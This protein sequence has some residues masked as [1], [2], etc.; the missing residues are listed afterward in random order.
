MKL[1]IFDIDGTLTATSKVDA[2]C[3]VAALRE[4]HNLEVDN[5]NWGQ[6]K[7]YTDSGIFAEVFE[8]KNSRQ[9]NADEDKQ[10]QEHFIMLLRQEQE[11]APELF[12]EVPGA[13]KMLAD[14][15]ARPGWRI[16]LATG[17][18][19]ASAE[20]KL[21]HIGVAATE[22]P[23]ATCDHYHRRQDIMMNAL[24]RAQE[25]YNQPE[26]ER[27]VY[28]GDGIWDARCSRELNFAFVGVQHE[29]HHKKL[30]G[31]GASHI[32]TNY[33]DLAQFMAALETAHSPQ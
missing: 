17:C 20:L 28:V 3:Y 7:N 9:P 2:D 10:V 21:R 14:M 31:E 32:V 16:A 4:I 33:L 13:G 5:S 23:L 8:K 19:R 1:A 22:I 15:Q 12:R 11:R 26:F 30:Q 6:F 24:E 18:W 29:E 27:I 25:A